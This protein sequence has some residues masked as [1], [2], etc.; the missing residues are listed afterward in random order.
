[1]LGRKTISRETAEEFASLVRQAL[2]E[3]FKDDFVFD[4]IAVESAIDHYGDEY[5]DTYIV[6]D[7]DQ[8]KLDPRWTAQLGV[9]IWGDLERMG[10]FNTPVFHYVVKNEW[11][12]LLHGKHPKAYEPR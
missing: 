12:E 2:E 4:P 7:G 3:R 5:L 11:E 6:F 10:I 1:M 8:K 9:L